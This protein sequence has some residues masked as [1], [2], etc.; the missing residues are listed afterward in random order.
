MPAKGHVKH[1]SIKDNEIQKK[2]S[3][4]TVEALDKIRD[5]ILKYMKDTGKPP[6]DQQ[7][8][9]IEHYTENRA[10]AVAMENAIEKSKVGLAPGAVRD[11]AEK[12]AVRCDILKAAGIDYHN[13]REGELKLLGEF[14][15]FECSYCGYLHKQGE[16]CPFIVTARN[17]KLDPNR[18]LTD[19]ELDDLLE[20]G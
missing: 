16:E 13:G 7:L 15:Y 4:E 14:D 3:Y 20:S 5:K 1:G 10:K 18:E 19:K 12:L 8:R 9:F 6:T 17:L 11:F 2:K